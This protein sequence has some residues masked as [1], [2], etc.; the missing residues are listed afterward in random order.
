MSLK[1]KLARSTVWVIAGSS[2]DQLTQFV[3]F[4]I[5]ARLL[6]PVDIGIVAFGIVLI[7]I[8]RVF[9]MSGL[10]EAMVQRSEWNDD[11]ASTCF[12]ANMGLALVFCALMTL[13]V[14]PLAAAYYEP[15]SG[16]I[17]I[18]LSL[19]FLIDAARAIHVA[20]LQREFAFKQLAVRGVTAKSLAGL[21]GIGLALTGFG[22]WSL[23][24]H[25]LATNVI[26]TLLTW[27]MARWQPRLRFSLPVLRE[28]TQFSA[29]LMLA[30]LVEVANTR[31]TEFLLGVV[32]GPAAVGFYAVGSRAMNAMVQLTIFPIRRAVFSA[33]SRVETPEGIGL[34][35]V[36]VVRA[37][38]I[39]TCPA[40]FGL[41]VVSSE[42]VGLLFG[43]RYET[44][45][46]VL[47]VLSLS[48]GVATLG[49]F[50]GPALTAAG[51]GSAI[52]LTNSAAAGS[53]LFLS[54]I[55][56]PFGPFAAACANTISQYVTLPVVLHLL[57]RSLSL[58]WRHVIVGI[59]PPALAGLGMALALFLIRRHFL[60][61]LPAAERAIIL[62]LAGVPIYLALLCIGGWRFVRETTSDVYPLL[63]QFLQIRTRAWALDVK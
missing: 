56:V 61:D 12:F 4:A 28:I 10:P 59:A 14:A 15:R 32:L 20:K 5:L 11:T 53:N 55:A 58:P 36:R 30:R 41:A 19:A 25:R 21:M 8:G 45:G 16:D 2:A 23:V 52:L 18:A 27:R 57:R 1:S 9:V 29:K 26:V 46:A 6:N 62:V 54:A 34:A 17:L 37:F 24:F 43:S 44:S 50:V 49:Y 35:L 48:G 31:M 40:Y 51:Q 3:I 22:I 7:E 33:L 42:V 13:C 38:A 39:L 60:M 63:P 47:A